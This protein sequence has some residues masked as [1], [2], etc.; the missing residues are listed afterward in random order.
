MNDLTLPAWPR[1]WVY[2]ADVRDGK[3]YMHS[4]AFA[5]NPIGVEFD[6]DDFV[7][8]FRAGAKEAELLQMA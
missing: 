1:D 3:A 8:R 4:A 2:F 7:A 6:P 5:A